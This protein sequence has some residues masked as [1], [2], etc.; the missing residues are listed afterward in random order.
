[1]A[2]T[3]RVIVGVSGSLNSLTALHRGL[4]EARRRN[5]FLVPVLAWTPPNGELGYRRAPC[6]PLLQEWERQARKRLDIAFEEALGSYPSGLRMQ[7]LVI[8]A[9]AG[10][11]LVETADRPEDLL[12]ISAG[13]RGYLN[14][15][16]HGS[17][18][19]YCLAHARCSV[20]AVPPSDL[21]RTLDHEGRHGFPLTI[22]PLPRA[23]AGGR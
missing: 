15:L 21:L 14:R 17:V 3:S 5:A 18:S 20:I 16:F 19:R 1:M 23:S 11:A 12:V 9:G 7:P 10:L 8:R 13:R 22:P 6:P 2:E 4:A